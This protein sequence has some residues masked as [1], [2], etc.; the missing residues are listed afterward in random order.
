METIGRVVAD[1]VSN[2]ASE[3]ALFEGGVQ[4][5]GRHVNWGIRLASRRSCRKA[6]WR[7]RKQ[8]RSRDAAGSVAL[9]RRLGPHAGG[10]GSYDN[11][12]GA[13]W[14]IRL[15]CENRKVSKRQ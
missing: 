3:A 14:T 7:V 6:Q 4:I 2:Y 9:R 15:A 11:E 5:R 1:G 10:S 12:N 8:R 13:V